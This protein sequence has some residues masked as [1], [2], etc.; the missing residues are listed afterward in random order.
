[1]IAPSPTTT[2]VPVM[3][4]INNRPLPRQPR[5]LLLSTIWSVHQASFGRAFS[6][7]KAGTNR[8]MRNLSSSQERYID[9][10]IAIRPSQ[11]YAGN[12]DDGTSTI[13]T[14]PFDW[15]NNTLF[16]QSVPAPSRK[17]GPMIDPSGNLSIMAFGENLLL[18]TNRNS[19][20]HG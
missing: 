16:E 1:M 12:F 15:W 13:V 4:S 9:S 20:N 2:Q 14:V 18:L 11:C 3:A 17:V 5:M 10:R 19:R 8:I 6:L 7:F